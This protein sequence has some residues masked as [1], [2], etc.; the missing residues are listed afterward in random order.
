MGVLTLTACGSR[1]SAP[2][3]VARGE[4]LHSA[5]HPAGDSG[6][7]SLQVQVEVKPEDGTYFLDGRISC[8]FTGE[9]ARGA[10]CSYDIVAVHRPPGG[11]GSEQFGKDTG[12]MVDC[13]A[14]R[15]P[16]VEGQCLF[17]DCRGNYDVDALF[18]IT[19]PQGWAWLPML[20]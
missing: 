6:V 2:G 19:L 7:C 10:A 12:G 13:Q 9:L 4:F 1:E 20:V 15:F 18:D 14:P 11:G 3:E 5:R 17:D 8:Q 16:P